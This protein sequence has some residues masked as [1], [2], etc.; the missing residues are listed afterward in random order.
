MTAIPKRLFF[1]WLGDEVP[2]YAQ[3]SMSAFK[4]VNPD[5]DAIFLHYTIDQLQRIWDGGEDDPPA[6]R[7]LSRV[8]EEQDDYTKW[9]L[10]FY[11][12][13]LSFLQ[14]LSDVL[15]VEVLNQHGGIYLDLDTFPIVKFDD[16]LLQNE[17]FAVKRKSG[18]MQPFFDNFFLG[19]SKSDFQV[20]SPYHVPGA[21]L[22][23]DTMPFS[24]TTKYFVLRKKFFDGSIQLGE[25]VLPP[26]SYVDHYS[27][28]T[29]KSTSLCG[30]KERWYDKTW[31]R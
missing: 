27:C 15:R 7:A 2:S 9:Q 18:G 6:K 22:V 20:Q 29:W 21:Y 1:I 24:S 25:H 26:S 31:R 5:F 3:T 30:C 14:L 23:D 8:L 19:K 12:S 13:H 4:K 16:S 11:G 28:G 10:D 17:F